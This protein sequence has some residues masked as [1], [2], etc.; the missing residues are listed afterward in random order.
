MTTHWGYVNCGSRHE[1]DSITFRQGKVDCETCK[2]SRTWQQGGKVDE[3]KKF[4]VG[5]VVRL[6]SGGP[7]MTVEGPTSHGI[8]CVWFND[9]IIWMREFNPAILVAGGEDAI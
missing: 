5:D 1:G 9:G 8:M 3:S 4:T 6:K 7:D 2:A